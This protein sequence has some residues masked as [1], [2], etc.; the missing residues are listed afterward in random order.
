MLPPLDAELAQM[1]AILCDKPVPAL[2]HQFFKHYAAPLLLFELCQHNFG[3]VGQSRNVKLVSG[4]LGGTVTRLALSL[5]VDIALAVDG[6][7]GDIVLS[8]AVLIQLDDGASVVGGSSSLDLITDN[9]RSS[10][11]GLDG[12]QMLFGGGFGGSIRDNLNGAGAV[13]LFVL[14]G[15][16]LAGCYNAG[17][18]NLADFAGDSNA[19]LILVSADKVRIFCAGSP[20]AWG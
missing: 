14:D 9:Q 1:D 5:H 19:S 15:R 8:L 18:G 11:M 12:R 7:S 17:V 4:D 20:S 3:F 13:V 6:Q 16:N 10:A 2:P